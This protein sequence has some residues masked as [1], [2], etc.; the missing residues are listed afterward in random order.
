[1]GANP[2]CAILIVL[3]PGGT[4]S[5]LSDPSLG[6]YDGQDDTLVGVQNSSGT[7]VSSI[8][9][10][11]TTNIFEFEHDGPCTVTPAPPGCTPE[12]VAG[13]DPVDYQ[14]P[15][16]TF[17][18]ISADFMSGTIDFTTPLADGAS[19]YFALEQ[20]LTPSQISIP[21][22]PS[23]I[24]TS[25]T[26]PP[27]T[28][29]QTTVPPTTGPTTIPPPGPEFEPVA[30]Q[31]LTPTVLEAVSPTTTSSL[32]TTGAETMR[33]VLIAALMVGA[34]AILELAAIRRRKLLRS[35]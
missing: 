22:P 5:V 7:T 18:N 4:V 15:N 14:G 6:A 13:T 25:T 17:S 26:R 35:R 8:N 16:N 3:N 30:V 34:G 28:T 33:V 31:S 32:A 23:T 10:T 1:M 9:L 21:N 20:A 12:Q 29:S 2:S 19:T 11:S 24:P 27:P